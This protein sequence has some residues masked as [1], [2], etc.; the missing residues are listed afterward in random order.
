MELFDFKRNSVLKTKFIKLSLLSGISDVIN[1][2]RSLHCKNFP[3]LETSLRAIYAV[4][5]DVGMR[6]S[7]FVYES[8]WKQNDVAPF[9]LTDTNLKNSLLLSVKYFTPNIKN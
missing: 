8:D 7:I 9:R 4:W 5:N 3:E 1:F 6:T 2:W